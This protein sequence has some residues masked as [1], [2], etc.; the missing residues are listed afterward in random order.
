MPKTNLHLMNRGLSLAND[1]MNNLV[2]NDKF[3]S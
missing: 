3:L 2:S 1:Y